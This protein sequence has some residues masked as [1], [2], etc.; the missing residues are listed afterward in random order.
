MQTQ[1]VVIA[2][3]NGPGLLIRALYF[4]LFGWWFSGIW[5]VVAWI[6]CLT[7]IGL[8]FGLYMLNRLPQVVTL[9]PSRS[10]LVLTTTGRVIERDVPQLPF[11]IRA[12]YFLLIG[13]WLSAVWIAIAWAL[14]ASIIGMVI[15]FWMFDRVPALITLA[16]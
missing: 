8:P 1:P 13:W 5:A 6:L 2:Q 4:I 9:R 3:Q 12:L 16:R 11:L 10:D 7:I 14:N 15:G